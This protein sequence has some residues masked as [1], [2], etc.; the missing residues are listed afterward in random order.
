MEAFFRD[1]LRSIL[2]EE[3]A[4]LPLAPG[5]CTCQKFLKD[6]AR[7]NK[8]L[9]EW[10]TTGCKEESNNHIC[11]CH[12]SA[13]TEM[14]RVVFGYLLDG[15]LSL[16]HVCI[17]PSLVVPSSSSSLTLGYKVCK[18]A[19]GRHLCICSKSGGDSCRV[20]KVSH[21]TAWLRHY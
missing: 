9:S 16:N 10:K 17:C 12:P 14:D 13:Q 4:R 2:E 5:V 20:P 8:Q 19:E 11:V 15:C 3:G 6:I 1:S 21:S 18:A 7:G